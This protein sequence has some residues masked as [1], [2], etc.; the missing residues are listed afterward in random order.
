MKYNSLSSIFGFFA[1][2]AI[3]SG[4]LCYFLPDP[5]HKEHCFESLDD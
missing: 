3:L 1:L 2:A 5:N 4:G